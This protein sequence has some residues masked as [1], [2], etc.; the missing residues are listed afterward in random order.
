MSLPSTSRWPA[1]EAGVPKIDGDESFSELVDKLSQSV[2][3]FILMLYTCL[4]EL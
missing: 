2:T 4:M 3:R 1:D